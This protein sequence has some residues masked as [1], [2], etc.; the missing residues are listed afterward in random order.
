MLK[1]FILS[2]ICNSSIDFRDRSFI[3]SRV[4]ST[5]VNSL[6]NNLRSKAK[7][8]SGY[9]VNILKNIIFCLWMHYFGKYKS[10]FFNKLFYFGFNNILFYSFLLSFFFH[11]PSYSTK[12]K[13]SFFF[14][15][16]TMKVFQCII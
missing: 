2:Q 5:F 8:F 14:F 9:S 10:T 11:L 1:Y 6:Q 15:H 4:N 7:Y 3:Q 13:K 12:I 16:Y